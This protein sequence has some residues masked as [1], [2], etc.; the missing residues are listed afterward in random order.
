MTERGRQGLIWR[1]AYFSLLL[2]NRNYA[3]ERGQGGVRAA[4][5][6]RSSRRFPF[7]GFLI[8]KLLPIAA[9]GLSLAAL[10]IFVPQRAA[11]GEATAYDTNAPSAAKR[12]WEA[13]ARWENDYFGG[14]DRFY[15][16]GIALGASHTGPSWMDPVAN[17]L[18]W[19]QGRRTVGYELAQAMFTPSDTDRPFPDPNDRPY[20]GILAFG[21]TL[22]VDR[23]NS[24]HGLKFVTGVL[25]PWSL[26]EE[27]Q[28]WIHDLIGNDEAQGWDYQLENEP[29][30]NL[31]YEY[32]HKFRLAGQRNRWS[33]EILPI[34]GG[35]LGNMLTQGE[36]GGFLR[37]GYNVPDDF[38][39]SLVRGMG[40]MPP[41]RNAAQAGPKSGWGFSVY[42]GPFG[43]LVLRDIT[44]DGNTFE[45]SP[46]VDKKL[47]VPAAGFGATVGNRHFQFEL[48][49]V[50]W[51]EAF[52][53]QEDNEEF[54]S[55]SISYFF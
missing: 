14:T 6:H 35:W 24:Y 50:F 17:W 33:A 22:H 10:G 54:G 49:H 48:S 36:F 43:T 38:C 9:C 29:I 8:E 42:G 3:E 1:V 4:V 28:T 34:G 23:P 37:G 46:S 11:A 40:F 19:G 25:G 30:F 7:T 26:A 5:R 44:L 53:G 31:A 41:P 20:A 51:G 55:L 15:T 45:G 52:D 16:N 2:P 32:R 27:T 18:P 21:L 39:A 13:S 12:Q 47:F